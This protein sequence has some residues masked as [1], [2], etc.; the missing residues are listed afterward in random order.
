MAADSGGLFDVR[1][2]IRSM[3]TAYRQKF[4]WP[5]EREVYAYKLSV[6]VILFLLFLLVLMV[7]LYLWNNAGDDDKVSG[8]NRGS[9]PILTPKKAMPDSPRGDAISTHSAHLSFHR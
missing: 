9:V 8:C 4:H 6:G 3:V 1:S 5:L 2:F 7:L